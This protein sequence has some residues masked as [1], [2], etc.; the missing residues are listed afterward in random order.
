MLTN[1]VFSKIPDEDVFRRGESP[2][3][4]EGLYMTDHYPGRMIKWIAKK[5]RGDD[6]AIYCGWSCHNEAW[7][8]RQGD[9]VV[10]AD[11]IMF[12][13]PCDDIVFK[14]YRY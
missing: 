1:E 3:S 11:H 12:C 14:K 13:V 8:R 7:I 10:S 9:K 4:P 2:N 6:W 5:G